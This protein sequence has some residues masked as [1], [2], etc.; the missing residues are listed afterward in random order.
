MNVNRWSLLVAFYTM[1]ELTCLVAVEEN[2]YE[3]EGNA[4]ALFYPENLTGTVRPQRIAQS[5]V[6]QLL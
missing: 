3:Q 2:S 5:I 1:L 6:H 4:V